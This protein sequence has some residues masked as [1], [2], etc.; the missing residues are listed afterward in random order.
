M[1]LNLEENESAILFL[2]DCNGYKCSNP[3]AFLVAVLNFNAYRVKRAEESQIEA[4]RMGGKWVKALEDCNMKYRVLLQG[5]KSDFTD[6]KFKNFIQHKY[7]VI[8]GNN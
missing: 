6:E 5:D 2:D 1:E 4:T 8:K 7:K 3:K